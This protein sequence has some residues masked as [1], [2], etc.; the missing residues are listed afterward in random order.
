MFGLLDRDNFYVSCERV[1]Q[2]H[3]E[4]KPVVVL[5]NNDE[6]LTSRSDES[7]ALGLQMGDPYFQ[8][9]DLLHHRVHVFS[10][11]YRLYGDVLA[12]VMRCCSHHTQSSEQQPPRWTPCR[13][14]SCYPAAT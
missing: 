7:K 3:L 5:S 6:C 12:R 13:P 9:K 10:S 8:E 14:Q 4:R 2:S 11:N 1:F